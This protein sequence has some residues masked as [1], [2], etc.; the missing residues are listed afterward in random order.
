MSRKINVRSPYYVK[1]QDENLH[2][3]DLNLYVWLGTTSS[4]N[5]LRYT[6]RKT[7]IGSNNYV[8]FELSELINDFLITQYGL[9]STD[10]VWVKYDYQIY[11][12][13][14]I[15][16]GDLVISENMLAV[17]GY[18]YFE[19]GIQPELSKQLLQSN[20]V[21]Y[22]NQAED[23]VLPIWAEDLSTITINS[24]GGA[25]ANWEAVGNFWNLYNVSWG[26]VLDPIVVTDSG[27]SNQKIQYVR[28]TSTDELVDGDTITITSGVSG[29]T[30]VVTLKKVCEPKYTP[31]NVIFFNKFGALQNV[32]FFKKSVTSI[33]VSN[34]VYKR[35]IMDFSSEPDYSS[36][37][38]QASTFNANGKETLQA[39][40]G[41]VD[42]QYN[43]VIRQLLLSEQV[44]VDNGIEVLPIR[45]ITSSLQFKTGVNDKLINYTLDFEYAFD[46]IN[47]I[48]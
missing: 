27:D 48:R 8:V 29:P 18:G 35:S 21:I 22:F 43:D 44:W 6:L 4:P 7:E 2:Y 20:T 17:N 5:T 10:C 11:D 34:E 25:N 47:N 46:K 28:I 32:W 16:V 30:T 19:E 3:V 9:F 37:V 42:E 36:Q 33:N 24:T 26:V 14:D 45:P 12:V 41:F 13:E 15:G 1:V 23:I 38:H 40:T 31:L 39:N